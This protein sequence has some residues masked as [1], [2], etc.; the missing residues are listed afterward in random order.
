MATVKE[1]LDNH[2]AAFG[3]GDLDGILADYA[4]D[5][6]LFTARGPLHGH[7]M[8]RPMFQAMIAEFAKPGM[9][10]KLDY[11]SIAGEYAFILWHGETADNVYELATDTFRVV[12]GKIVMQSFAG[13]VIPKPS[14]N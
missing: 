13:L 2:I 6:V 10:F 1:V 5:A 7:A 4:P 3:R 12:G 8:I 9:A 14:Y 11:V